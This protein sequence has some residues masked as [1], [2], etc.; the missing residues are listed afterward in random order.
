MFC[1]YAIL[2]TEICV[3]MFWPSCENFRQSGRLADAQWQQTIGNK[4]PVKIEMYRNSFTHL[5]TK[6]V[7]Y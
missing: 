7:S 5:S 2:C 3:E 6:N 1:K 4:G